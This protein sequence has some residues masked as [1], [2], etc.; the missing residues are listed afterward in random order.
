MRASLDAHTMQSYPI[1]QGL[2]ES[3]DAILFTKA[4]A[5]AKDIANEL[6]ISPQP[7]IDSLKKEERG[8]FTIIPDD[9]TSYQC[10]ALVQRGLTQVRCRYPTLAHNPRLCSAH[11][12]NTLDVPKLPEVQRIITP[13]SEYILKGKDVLTLNGHQCGILK[14]ST[15]TLFEIE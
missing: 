11:L 5:L 4:I 9:D 3:I 10:C 8:K 6:N 15:L 14:G 13:D 1:Q 2:W 12:S 7:L